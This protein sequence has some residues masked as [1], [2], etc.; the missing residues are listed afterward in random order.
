M[1]LN[2]KDVFSKISNS[3]NSKFLLT[4]EGKHC[5]SKG[6]KRED[7]VKSFLRDNN[8]KTVPSIVIFF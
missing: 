4:K 7:I 1:A 2:V 5:L 8:I 6:E 3:I